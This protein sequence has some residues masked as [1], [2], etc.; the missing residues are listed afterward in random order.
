MGDNKMKKTSLLNTIWIWIEAVLLATL[1][2][3]TI[4]YAKDTN[5][6]NVIGYITGV[7]ILIDGFLRLGLFILTRSINVSKMDLYRGIVEVTF[8]V[9][10][11]IRPEI[12]VSYFTLFIAIALVVIGVVCIIE[13]II[14]NVRT[15]NLN[16]W[17]LVVCYLL[18]LLVLATGIV[19]LVYYPYDLSKVGGDN[20][21]SIL[22]IVIG[23][24]FIL[25]AIFVVI[26]SLVNK[27]K[28]ENA[29]H[30]EGSKI[31]EERA[32]KREAKQKK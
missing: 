8:G 23:V 15:N 26:A 25:T 14:S 19:A 22:L 13:C 18:S 9:F 24:V 10:L 5:A 21:I 31:E 1:G 20:T 17:T 32:K 6:W 16:K 28:E 12:V 29:A 11:L 7:L 30:K 3:L 4:A 2:I 27:K